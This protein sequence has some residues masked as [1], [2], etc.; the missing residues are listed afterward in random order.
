MTNMKRA[1]KVRAYIQEVVSSCEKGT[2]LFTDE[3][4]SAL[5]KRLHHGESVR[6]V[7]TALRER[8]DVR[9]IRTGEWVKL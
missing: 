8:D 5:C 9:L 1:P 3:L 7:G 6:D 2:I 4:A